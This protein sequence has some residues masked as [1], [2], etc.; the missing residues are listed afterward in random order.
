[1]VKKVCGF[2]LAIFAFSIHSYGQK[3]SIRSVDFDD[4]E[5]TLK[6]VELSAKGDTVIV[7]FFLHS[8]LKEPRELKLNTF[9]SGVISPE[10][11]VLFYDTIMMGKVRLDLEDRQNYIHYLLHRNKPVLYVTKT[12]N[13]QKR[14]GKPQQFRVTLEDHKEEGKFLQLDIP[15]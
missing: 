8:Y 14:W 2:V 3:D 6:S 13:W 4:I 11:R 1:M 12:P 10:G 7:S 9:A 15:L 5:I